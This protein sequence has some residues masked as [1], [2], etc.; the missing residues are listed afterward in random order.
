MVAPKTPTEALEFDGL[1]NTM[2]E[3]VFGVESVEGLALD[4]KEKLTVFFRNLVKGALAFVEA[5]TQERF[6]FE[7]AVFSLVDTVQQSGGVADLRVFDRPENSTKLNMVCSIPMK[8]S[9]R[10]GL[11]DGSPKIT[12]AKNIPTLVKRV[13]ID[14]VNVKPA[15]YNFR[16]PAARV[17]TELKKKGNDFVTHFETQLRPKSK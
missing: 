6:S 15:K 4:E 8:E 13:T 2:S 14:V 12:D 11:P 5:K 17:A 16:T 3:R 7:R 9:H 1:L 10:T